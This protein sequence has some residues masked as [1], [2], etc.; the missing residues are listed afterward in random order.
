[1]KRVETFGTIEKG[2]LKIGY[3]DKFLEAIKSMPDCRIKIRVE[4]LY[5]KRSTYTYNEETEKQ[6]TGQNGYYWL[7]G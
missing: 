1:M 7:F 4:K 3:R 6:G 2:L 5:K